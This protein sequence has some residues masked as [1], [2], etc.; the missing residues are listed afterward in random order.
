ME[1]RNIAYS[2]DDYNDEAVTAGLKIDSQYYENYLV[3]CATSDASGGSW[4]LTFIK[5][6]KV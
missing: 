6:G 3:F 2:F 1:N 5:S 4:S